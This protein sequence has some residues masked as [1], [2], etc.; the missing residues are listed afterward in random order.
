MNLSDLTWQRI[1]EL[2]P[3]AT[4]VFPLAAVEQHGHHLPVATDS[5]LVDEVVRRVQGKLSGDRILFAPLQWLGNSDHHSNFAG[6]LS[7]SPRGYLDLINRLIDNAINHGFR[8]IVFLN[9]HGGNEIPGRQ[10]VFE[11]RQRYRDRDDLLLLLT[12]YWDHAE[13]WKTRDD[14]VQQKIGH[15]CEWETSMILTIRPDLVGDTDALV[16]VSPGFGFEPAYR[17][18]ITDERTTTGHIG[19]PRHATSE[20]GEHLLD[21]FSSGVAEFLQRVARWDASQSWSD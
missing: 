13:P 9:G 12:S 4:I 11:S 6:T 17:G 7:A 3:G 1:G 18:W 5:M 19:S 10:S 15:A 20:K 21:A 14:F 2:A 8:R 16:D